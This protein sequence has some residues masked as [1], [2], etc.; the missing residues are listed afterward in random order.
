MTTSNT[1]KDKE[2]EKYSFNAKLNLGKHL[3]PLDDAVSII[4]FI[5]FFLLFLFTF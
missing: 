1:E 4:G 5:I 3:K 2:R